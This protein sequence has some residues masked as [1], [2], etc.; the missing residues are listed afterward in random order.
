MIEFRCF[1]S[2]M[3]KFDDLVMGRRPSGV[4]DPTIEGANKENWI[5][6]LYEGDFKNGLPNGFCR[7]IDAL[8][9]NCQ[10]GYFKE[11][12]AFGKYAEINILDGL[13]TAPPG[14]Y[15]GKRNKVESRAFNDY[16]E[17]WEPK[18]VPTTK[19]DREK[20][21]EQSFMRE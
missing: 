3:N 13:E 19:V 11:A 8:N 14:L 2:G 18:I 12:K 7:R 17:N 21:I 4:A 6:A 10:M 15:Y 5:L 1:A 16:L 20:Q 9:G